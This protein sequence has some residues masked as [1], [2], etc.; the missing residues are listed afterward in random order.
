[1]DS[2]MRTF[3][4]MVKALDKQRRHRMATDL[5]MQRLAMNGE[6]KHVKET[7]AKLVPDAERPEEEDGSDIDKFVSAF[8]GGI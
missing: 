8:G 5:T 7:M 6:A 1:M 4:E 3:R 2:D